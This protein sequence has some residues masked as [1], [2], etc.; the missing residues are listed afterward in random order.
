[1]VKFVVKHA[2]LVK[3]VLN[4]PT[5]DPIAQ[6]LNRLP[7]IS[8]ASVGR[9]HVSYTQTLE[10]GRSV[11][12]TAEMNLVGKNLVKHLQYG[13]WANATVWDGQWMRPIV[14]GLSHHREVK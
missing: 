4:S 3:G 1:M 8:A 2:D 14:V 9:T 10:D 11:R 5:S 7:N 12:I 13:D 6:A